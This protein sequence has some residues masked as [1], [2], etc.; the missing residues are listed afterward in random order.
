MVVGAISRSWD[1]LHYFFS[2]VSSY[3]NMINFSVAMI[4]VIVI[5]FNADNLYDQH[6]SDK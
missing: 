6:V 2:T 3:K 5:V 1:G 4:I